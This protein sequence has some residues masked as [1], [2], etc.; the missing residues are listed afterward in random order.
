MLKQVQHDI[1]A[2]LMT[3]PEISNVAE[4]FSLAYFFFDVPFFVVFLA[5]GCFIPH[6][7]IFSPPSTMEPHGQA[8]G[9]SMKYPPT[10]P[11]RCS[12]SVRKRQGFG[13]LSAISEIRRSIETSAHDGF[14]KHFT[15]SSTAKG[16]GFVHR[17][18]N[19]NMKVSNPH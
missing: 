18:I 7:I 4:Y 1:L 6:A 14:H 10:P 2:H 17:R 11:G 16:R 15:H 19:S 12:A 3:L 13:G 8:R 5:F 9:I